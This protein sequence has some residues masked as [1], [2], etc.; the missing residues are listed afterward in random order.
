MNDHDFVGCDIPG[1]EDLFQ[2]LANGSNRD[3]MRWVPVRS[4][5]RIRSHP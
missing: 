2:R 4:D 5:R 3:A 1:L